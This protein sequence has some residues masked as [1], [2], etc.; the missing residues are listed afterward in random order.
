MFTNLLESELIYFGGIFFPI[1]LLGFVSAAF[2]LD[3]TENNFH[4]KL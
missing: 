2:K 1:C 3:A 4:Q